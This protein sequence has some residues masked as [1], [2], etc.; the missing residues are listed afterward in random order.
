MDDSSEILVFMFSFKEFPFRTKFSNVFSSVLQ[1]PERIYNL[2]EH[3][4]WSF[5]KGTI[6]DVRLGSKYASGF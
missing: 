5:Q 1:Q 4:R 6:V 2:V 3:Q